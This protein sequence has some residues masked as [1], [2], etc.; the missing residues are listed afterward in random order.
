MIRK[1]IRCEA[2]RQGLSGYA[3]AKLAGVPLRTAQRFMA[4]D[5]NVS[6]ATAEAFAAVLGL[7][8]RKVRKPKTK[9]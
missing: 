8:L 1:T 4:G 9:G 7:E 3:L 5:V 6:A 2:K